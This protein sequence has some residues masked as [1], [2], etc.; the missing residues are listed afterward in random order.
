MPVVGHEKG[1]QGIR[2]VGSREALAC[3]R[4]EGGPELGVAIANQEAWRDTGG[5]AL[6][7]SCV[8]QACDGKRAVSGE[9]RDAG[10]H[11]LRYRL[12]ALRPMLCQRRSLSDRTIPRTSLHVGEM[13]ARATKALRSNRVTRRRPFR[14][15]S[16]APF[17]QLQA[18]LAVAR[19][20]S[21]SGAAREL[22]VWRSAVSQT[23]QQLE[24]QLRVGLLALCYTQR[25]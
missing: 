2:D 1:G 22:R 17:Q 3:E 8:T 9:R 15:V 5:V 24:E 7:S 11:R 12:R 19:H 20:R 18:F 6:R 14:L 21:F 13:A 4:I 10:R 16:T 25:I 23:V